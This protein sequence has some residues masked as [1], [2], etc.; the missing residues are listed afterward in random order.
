[1]GARSAIND[2]AAAWAAIRAAKPDGWYVGR[3]T[4]QSTG[5]WAMYAFDV[6]ADARAGRPTREWNVVGNTETDCVREMARAL[7]TFGDAA[8]LASSAH[9]ERHSRR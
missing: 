8:T 3:P 1:M 4:Q 2:L 7:R 9:F 6:T 5:H